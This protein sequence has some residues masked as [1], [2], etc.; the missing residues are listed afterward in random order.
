MLK[1][2]LAAFLVTGVLVCGAAAADF[3]SGRITVTV[4]G[5]GPDVVLI[6]GLAS[7]SAVW[8]ATVKRLEGRYRLH[9]VQ[10][11]GFAGAASR[12]NA[13]GPVLQPAVDAIDA[14]IKANKLRQ[15]S[16]I[17]HSFGGLAG[18]MLA[19][20]HSEDVGRL[21]VV[22]SLPFFSVLM[23]A[24]DAAAA[25]PAAAEM[26]DN[27]MAQSQ[28]DY[29]LTEFQ[30]MPSMVKS[31]DGC[32]LATQWA[33]ASDKSVVA[34]AMYD[35][36][37]TDMRPKLG[38]IETPVTVLYPWDISM[39]M[40]KSAS[41]SA[42]S[43]SKYRTRTFLNSWVENRVENSVTPVAAEMAARTD[44]VSAGSRPWIMVKIV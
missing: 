6:P 8:D 18:L 42:I 31:R 32:K 24:K 7:S 12:G 36:M 43:G 28:G 44:C 34:R 23:G 30:V 13:K 10:V 1:S 38:R 33:I 9:V 25:A 4:H 39:G 2:I 26:R 41:H 37:T 3:S 17:G 40:P 27:T 20:Q 16:V 22:D 29:A 14:Y 35:D 21:M 19:Q 11:A 5:H 15:P